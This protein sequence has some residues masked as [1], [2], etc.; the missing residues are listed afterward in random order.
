MGCGCKGYLPQEIGVVK[1]KKPDGGLIRVEG[2][3]GDSFELHSLDYD[4]EFE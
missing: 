3:I 2:Q 4:L 1:C